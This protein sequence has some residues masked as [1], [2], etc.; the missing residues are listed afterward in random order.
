MKRLLPHCSPTQTSVNYVLIKIFPPFFKKKTKNSCLCHFFLNFYEAGAV[1]LPWINEFSQCHKWVDRHFVL[2]IHYQLVHNVLAYMF[3]YLLIVYMS[4]FSAVERKIWKCSLSSNIQVNVAWCVCVGEGSQECENITGCPAAGWLIKVCVCH[5][6]F[7]K[8]EGEERKP[9]IVSN[10]TLLNILSFHWHF[11]QYRNKIP[12]KQEN[13]TM[14][15]QLETFTTLKF[16]M[17]MQ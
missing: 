14:L 13:A 6:A 8:M 12:L 5:A 7:E 4:H 11:Y 9:D 17:F 2:S 3:W 15:Y 16:L 10:T 1:F